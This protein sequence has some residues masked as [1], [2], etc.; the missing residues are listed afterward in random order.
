MTKKSTKRRKKSVDQPKVS[1]NQLI[2]ESDTESSESSAE[3]K[4]RKPNQQVTTKNHS[5]N[6]MDSLMM[7]TQLPNDLETESEES[8]D[9]FQVVAN[10]SK[11]NKASKSDTASK[12]TTPVNQRGTM[13]AAQNQPAKTSSQSAGNVP[14][15]TKVKPI[16]VDANYL[17]ALNTVKSINVTPKPII[18]ILNKDSVSIQAADNESKSK[19]LEALTNKAIHFHSYT[20]KENRKIMVAL[21]GYFLCSSDE[22]LE[23]LKDA[24]IPAYRASILY[25]NKDHPI[26]SVQFLPGTMTLLKLQQQHNVIDYLKVR[27]ESIKPSTKRI[28]QCGTCKLWGHSSANC[29]R[30]Y[31]CIKCLNDHRPGECLRTT[32]ENTDLSQVACVNCK[33]QHPANSIVCP[34]FKDYAKKM[35]IPLD[36]KGVPVK[37]SKE[38]EQNTRP[39]A[40]S[41]D[42]P[43]R[44]S[45]TKWPKPPD[46]HTTTVC[47]TEEPEEH[48]HRINPQK[49]ALYAEKLQAKQS[50]SVS[51][52]NPELRRPLMSVLSVVKPPSTS[53]PILTDALT[54]LH[55]QLTT[56]IQTLNDSYLAIC[57]NLIDQYGH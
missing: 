8:D 29:N 5:N 52:G 33:G 11:Q 51:S 54:Q 48:R 40:A 2:D 36:E 41:L 43:P 1:K 46:D 47:Q 23:T 18:R 55:T 4:K 44:T 13:T 32:K 49:R 45:T 25:N 19:I 57:Q 20:E 10:K 35:K 16:C 31:R 9:G 21:K 28:T 42:P 17:V 22:L 14:K 7:S 27:W 15:T 6:N 3:S 30:P 26:Y 38:R 12:S 34:A 37:T 56:I 39:K 50:S 53:N 24:N